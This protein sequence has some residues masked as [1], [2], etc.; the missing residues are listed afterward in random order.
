MQA[1]S[2]GSQNS[3]VPC[4]RRSSRNYD[5]NDNLFDKNSSTTVITAITI[6]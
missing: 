6:N 5:N 4:S 2:N 1:I 3:D